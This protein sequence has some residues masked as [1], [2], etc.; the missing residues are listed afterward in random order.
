LRKPRRFWLPAPC[1]VSFR[2]ISLPQGIPSEIPV[3][4]TISVYAQIEHASRKAVKILLQRIR[5]IG[6]NIY[7][8]HRS[9]TLGLHFIER[10]ATR[11]CSKVCLKTCP[12]RSPRSRFPSV[13]ARNL[14]LRQT[15]AASLQAPT[16]RKL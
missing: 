13:V 14:D 7:E 2:F 3:F 11:T 6:P 9:R 12:R 16:N 1:G 10:G 8:Y 15:E 4:Y 5:A